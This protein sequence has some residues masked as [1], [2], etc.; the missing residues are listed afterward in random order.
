M[1]MQMPIVAGQTGNWPVSADW[2]LAAGWLG[3]AVWLRAADR[4]STAGQRVAERL[5]AREPAAWAPPRERVT[6]SGGPGGALRRSVATSTSP[7]VT[8]SID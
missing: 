5:A 3:A 6:R 1:K 7:M 4:P 2:P 8:N